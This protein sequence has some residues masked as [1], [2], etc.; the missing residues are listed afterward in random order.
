[1]ASKK[2][3]KKVACHIAQDVGSPYDLTTVQPYSILCSNQATASSVAAVRQLALM[4]KITLMLQQQHKASLLATGNNL[5]IGCTP[6]IST[7]S[8]AAHS[9]P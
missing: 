5:V 7:Y 3:S 9:A 4:L 1:M 6:P 2:E 8:T